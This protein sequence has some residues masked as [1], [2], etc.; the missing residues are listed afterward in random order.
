MNFNKYNK[1]SSLSKL[2]LNS[3]IL[4]PTRNY[5]QKREYRSYKKT[6]QKTE[7]RTK[8]KSPSRKFYPSMGTEYNP[9]HADEDGDDIE[10]LPN[11][12]HWNPC[13]FLLRFR[14][15]SL[16]SIAFSV[17]IFALV[18]TVAVPLSK[19]SKKSV[20]YKAGTYKPETER[21][22]EIYTSILDTIVEEA[23]EEEEANINVIGPSNGIS[24]STVDESATSSP[25]NIALAGCPFCQF[26]PPRIPNTL[27]ATN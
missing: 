10:L 1:R 21:F 9:N 22:Q 8:M 6:P 17:A 23:Q 2:N 4:R 18:I 13:L 14:R 5:H 16:I 3:T 19:R 12:T 20:A 15:S 11:P 25:T 7:Q 24:G 27:A 26:G